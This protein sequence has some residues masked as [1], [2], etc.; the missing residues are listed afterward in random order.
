[1]LSFCLTFSYL[2]VV[3]I[4]AP[5]ESS[6]T[7]FSIQSSVCAPEAQETDSCLWENDAEFSEVTHKQ[8]KS[9]LLRTDQPLYCCSAADPATFK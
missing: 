7:H 3:F 1:M 9:C 5:G 8:T 6:T 4:L 2:I